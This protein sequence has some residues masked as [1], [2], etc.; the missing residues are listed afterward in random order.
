MVWKRAKLIGLLSFPLISN[1][2]FAKIVTLFEP[3]IKA[4]KIYP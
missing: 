1:I 2:S 3:S 4:S